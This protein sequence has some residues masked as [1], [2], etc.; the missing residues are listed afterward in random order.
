M[1]IAES[2]GVCLLHRFILRVPLTNI[3]KRFGTCAGLGNCFTPL[4]RAFH[5]GCR[6][7]LVLGL[8]GRLN[9]ACRTIH[10]VP[11][12][13]DRGCATKLLRIRHNHILGGMQWF[14]DS[15]VD[16]AALIYRVGYIRR[17]GILRQPWSSSSM[18]A[19]QIFHEDCDFLS[20]RSVLRCRNAISWF[21]IVFAEAE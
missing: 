21:L 13:F 1:R 4:G 11:Q 3:L 17:S 6:A 16:A 14:I 8:N 12:E 7:L 5:S 20:S 9:Q 15:P 10:V 18:R 2:S 19:E